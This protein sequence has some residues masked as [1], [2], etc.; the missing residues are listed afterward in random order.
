M[1]E[2]QFLHRGE[3]MRLSRQQVIEA[4]GHEVPNPGSWTVMAIGHG[5]AT[6]TDRQAVGRR[7]LLPLAPA[8][9]S[10]IS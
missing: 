1:D 9:Y 6:S 4:M 8:Y 5:L 10:D 3:Q 2:V 7:L